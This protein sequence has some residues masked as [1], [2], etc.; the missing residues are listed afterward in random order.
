MRWADL[1]PTPGRRPSWSIRSWTG[2]AYNES[3]EQ[4]AEAAE[5]EAAHRLLGQLVDLADGVVNGGEDEVFEH[6]NVG[7]IDRRGIDRH[8]LELHGAGDRHLHDAAPRMPFHDLVGRR[9][10]GLHQL[11]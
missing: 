9:L 11:L 10:L 7:G 6:G 2:P 5:V 3:A 8:R 1:G 4:A